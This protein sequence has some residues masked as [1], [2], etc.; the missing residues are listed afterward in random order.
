VC[1]AASTGLARVLKKDSR[2]P[3]RGATCMI[4]VAFPSYHLFA[5]KTANGINKVAESGRF[6]PTFWP[7]CLEPIPTIQVHSKLAF[8]AKIAEQKTC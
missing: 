7:I 5:N 6:K 1:Q 3:E 8:F 2:P 4:N